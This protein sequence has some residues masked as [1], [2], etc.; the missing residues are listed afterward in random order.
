MIHKWYV[1]GEREGEEE[2]TTAC[3]HIQSN[4]HTYTL[5]TITKGCVQMNIAVPECQAGG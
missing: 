1:L 2:K 3:K 5:L 4:V